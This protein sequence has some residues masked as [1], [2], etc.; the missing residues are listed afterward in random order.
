M[1]TKVAVVIAYRD[2]GDA[3]RRASFEYVS[4]FYALCGYRVF[5]NGGASDALFTRARAING[6]IRDCA[7]DVIIQSDPDSLVQPW[8]LHEAV[9][10]AVDGPGL[11]VP[12]SRY[13]YTTEETTAKILDGRLDLDD[14]AEGRWACEEIGE[15]GVGN[16][17]VFTRATWAA[18]G[19]FD[20]RFPMWGGDDAAFAYACEALVAPMRRVQGDMVHLWHPRLPQSVPGD[21]GYVEQ[22]ALLREYRDANAVGAGAVRELVTN[23]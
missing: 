23:R 8:Q 16:V 7:A 1:G 3:A 19:G 10:M 12:F 14:S 15:G 22:F 6:A 5:T 4:R 17:T 11:V 2:M 21:P 18:A 20:E 9:E 13:L